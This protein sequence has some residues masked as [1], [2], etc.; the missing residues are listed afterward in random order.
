VLWVGIL[1]ALGARASGA[2]VGLPPPEVPRGF[3]VNIHFTDPG[4][5]VMGRFAQAGFRLARMDLGWAGV[6]KTK[7]RFDF[8]A[9]D[10][11]VTHLARANARPLFILDYAN[12]LYDGGLAP[13]TEAGRAAFARFAA[14][15]AGHFRGRGVIWEI[16][17]EPNLAQFWKPGPDA[18]AYG[19]LALATARAVRAA[20]PDA[21]VI[22]PGSSQFP[23]PFFETVF[24][25]G[26][27]EHVDAVSVHPYRETA[28]ETAAEDFARLR[29]LIARY[30]PPAKR[31]L[32]IV[33]SEWGYSTA[34][35][36]VSEAR[37]AQYLARM[38]LS[39][40]AHG[41]DLSV[42][43]D[44]R[45]DGDNPDDR[46]HRFGTVRRDLTPKPSFEAA[47]SI[48]A[49]LNGY[50]FRHRLEGTGPDDWRLLF[51]KGDSDALALATW[52]AS[53]T[54]PEVEQTPRVQPVA[55]NDPA[56][57]GLRRLA[58]VHYKAGALAEGTGQAAALA[59]AVVNA[60]H[61]PARLTVAPAGAAHA[62]VLNLGPGRTERVRVTLPANAERSER[63]SVALRLLWGDRPLPEVVPL[64]VGR[65]DPLGLTVAPR[66][67]GLEAR[68][69]NPA[70]TA[71]AGRLSVI[72]GERTV[73][74]EA[75]SLAAGAELALLRVPL[76]AG[77]HR[78]TLSDQGGTV[79]ARLAPRRYVPMAGFPGRPGPA[80]G[81]QLVVSVDNVA[82]PATPLSAVATGQGGPA[83][84]ALAVGYDFDR[85]WRYEQAVPDR[86]ATVPAGARALTLWV[87]SG[88]DDDYLR[89]RF[90]DSTGQTFQAD[91]G[92]LGWK[93]WRPLTVPLD[94]A[95]TGIHWGGANDGVPHPPLAWEGLILIDSA[96]RDRPHRGEVLVAAPFY[97][98][99]E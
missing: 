52:S 57:A 92:R 34:K 30:A 5:G 78:V 29:A 74:S 19:R 15:A 45:D 85:G 84:A 98:L 14:A 44:W 71:F 91:L 66:S 97:V 27:L 96:R 20:D 55:T 25:M 94:G 89:S 16:W 23:W 50:T 63:R 59:V 81:F 87:R 69:E 2:D 75:V 41:V 18:E 24:R 9:Y 93:G 33:S 56:F 37:Q 58:S 40:L 13:H 76:P 54:A 22:A 64:N 99:G 95:G 61:A 68:V 31:G 67:D 72:S 35:G 82:R 6:E 12:P 73:A 1:A 46:E 83:G 26:V 53:P 38:W 10:R 49:A 32:P 62:T 4:P 70:R 7:G 86:T 48:V 90:R 42:F 88:P 43:Y 36:A 80:P 28:P 51:Q 65:T 39:N 17:N 77:V 47:R 79:V 60:E 11:L 8:S 3:G 21:V